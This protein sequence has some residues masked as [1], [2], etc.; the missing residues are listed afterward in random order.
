[1]LILMSLEKVQSSIIGFGNCQLFLLQYFNYREQI[2]PKFCTIN[3]RKFKFNMGTK[4]TCLESEDSFQNMNYKIL[5]EYHCE[6]ISV[7]MR[8][9]FEMLWRNSDS[10]YA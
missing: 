7:Q 9:N 6:K 3:Y 5:K 10:N 4:K 2:G 8:D 1:M